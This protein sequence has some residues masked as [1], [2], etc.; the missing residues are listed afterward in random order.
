MHYLDTAFAQLAFAAKLYDYAEDGKLNLEDFDRP[1]SFD[2]G[3]TKPHRCRSASIYQPVY[4]GKDT[5]PTTFK[6]QKID[7]SL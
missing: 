1:L 7:R 2:E 6:R 4:G 5:R 3:G